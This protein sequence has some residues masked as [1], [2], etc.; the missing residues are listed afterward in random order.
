LLLSYPPI[1]D[2]DK[3]KTLMKTAAIGLLALPC[4]LCCIATCALG[5]AFLFSLLF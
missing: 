3:E 4:L 2:I 1:G 5:L